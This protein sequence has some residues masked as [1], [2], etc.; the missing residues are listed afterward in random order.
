M[1]KVT[2]ES[3]GFCEDEVAFHS[4]HFWL[5]SIVRPRSLFRCL[6]KSRLLGQELLEEQTR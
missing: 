1:H 5:G 2:L 4:V 3:P 6:Y